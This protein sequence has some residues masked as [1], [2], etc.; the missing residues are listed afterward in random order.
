MGPTNGF[1]P[2]EVP[3]FSI[4]DYVK[5]IHLSDYL[6][7]HMEET[8]LKFEEYFTYLSKFDDYAI[9]SWFISMFKYEL[10]SSESIE[11]SHLISPERI[12]E[13]DPF[14]DSLQ[15][16]HER[17]KQLHNFVTNGSYDY[18]YRAGEV[19]VSYM[20]PRTKEEHI[21]WRGALQ[22]DLKKFMD[23]YISLYKRKSLSVLINNP[24][25]RSS[26]MHLLFV[27]IHPFSDGNGRTARLIHNMCFT[28][29]INKIYGMKLKICPLNLSQ[30][31]LIN[32][33][34]YVKRIDDIYFD[35]EHDCNDEINKWF[36]FMLNMVDDQLFYCEKR[37][38]QLKE[39][40][41]A[42]EKSDKNADTL[43]SAAKKMKIRELP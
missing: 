34:T 18:Q 13:E 10:Q 36:D 9:M 28:E 8:N 3:Y 16:S 17:I 23:D 29:S 21:Y 38:S 43:N 15:M 4:F 11:H 1:N 35:L 40:A 20:D 2:N 5:R 39:N 25:F 41:S 26:L 27:R 31:I 32:Q 19:K 42:I 33:P 14:F 22:K 6:L 24:F 12:C 30:S 7:E 37:L